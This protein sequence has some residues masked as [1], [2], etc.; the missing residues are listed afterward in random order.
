VRAKKKVGSEC[1]P[2]A[3]RKRERQI[4]DLSKERKK[5]HVVEKVILSH[6]KKG[7]KGKKKKG[8]D[9]KSTT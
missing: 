2:L 3:E 7:R 1:T 6:E 9:S 8:E 5:P 4:S